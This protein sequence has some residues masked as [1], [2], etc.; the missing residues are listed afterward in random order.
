MAVLGKR[1]EQRQPALRVRLVAENEERRNEAREILLKMGDPPVEIVETGLALPTPTDNGNGN[2]AI[3]VDV[4][5]VTFHG[6]EE[7]SLRYIQALHE[8]QPCPVIVALLPKGSPELMRRAL[9]AGADELIFFPVELGDMTRALVKIE[10]YRRNE[11]IRQG[12]VVVSLASTLGGVGVTSLTA[13]LAL[14][15]RYSLRKK[16]AVI[17]LDL[18]SGGLSVGLNIEPE[19]TIMLLTEPDKKLDSIQL[20]SALTK[21]ES[22]IYLL[23]SPKRMED[24]E[25]VPDTLIGPI[26]DLMRQLFD[27]VLIDCGSYINEVVVASW[28]H[29]D[30]LLYLLDQSISAARCTWRFI[31]LYS[32][33]GL[34]DLEP[35][36]VLSRHNPSHPITEEQIMHT[37]ARPVFAKIPRDEKTLERVQLRAQDLWK[38]A[39]NSAF[40]RSIEELARRIAAV[41][42]AEAP[43]VGAGLLSRLFAAIAARA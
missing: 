36:I 17:D 38:I 32:R 13:N 14:A 8:S 23:A 43:E 34:K 10:S 12:G 9:K 7:A 26:I 1:P 29:S 35:N 40:T 33:L 2:G 31:E 30:R 11:D 39:P 6:Q 22:G 27:F 25:L 19:R 5:I 15:L 37:L 16:V 18:Q 4:V 3:A 41:D 42:L 20:E 21:H 24:C 28:E